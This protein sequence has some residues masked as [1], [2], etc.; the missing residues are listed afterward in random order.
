MNNIIYLVFAIGALISGF[1]LLR[2]F[3]S[4]IF[5]TSNE[6]LHKKRLKQLQTNSKRTSAESNQKEMIAKFT[7]PVATHIIPKL[8]LKTDVSQLEKDLE[9]SQWNQYYTPVTF[10]AMDITLKIIGVVVFLLLFRASIYF[11]LLISAMFIF[12]FKLLFKNSISNRK[13]KLLCEFPE[14]IRIT[15]GFLI[16][17]LPLPQAIENALPYVGDEWRPIL[18]EF[19]VNSEIYSQEE[20]IDIISSR[21][22]IFEVRELWSLIKLNSEQGIDIKECFANQADKIRQLQLQVMLDKIHKREMMSVAI[23]APLLLVM[24]VGFGLPTFNSMVNLGL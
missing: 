23:Q 2:N 21:V 8:K 14:F 12:L 10:I 13:F 22:D 19:V 24:I 17:G 7:N 6:S 5:S 11:A 3:M 1:F 18:R 20:C 15:Q 16:S 9:M 4:L